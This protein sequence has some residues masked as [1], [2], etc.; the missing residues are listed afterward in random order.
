MRCIYKYL[1]WSVNYASEETYLNFFDYYY[2]HA[3]TDSC[4]YLNMFVLYFL[5]FL[6]LFNSKH[7]F[8]VTV[9]DCHTE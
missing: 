7:H 5:C 4:V 3:T 8:Y 9:C 1:I 2:C 6:S